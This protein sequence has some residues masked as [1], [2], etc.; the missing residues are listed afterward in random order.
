MDTLAGEETFTPPAAD[1]A[2]PLP[3]LVKQYEDRPDVPTLSQQTL[4]QHVGHL[5]ALWT[6][7]QAG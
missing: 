7:A 5:G 4:S 6:K 3:V 1:R 2:T